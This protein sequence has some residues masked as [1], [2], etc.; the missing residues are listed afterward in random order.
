[1]IDKIKHFFFEARVDQN[2]LPIFRISIAF[3][4]L[5]HFL[6][7]QEDFFELYAR[8]GII[9]GDIADFF[10]HRYEPTLYKLNLFLENH[11]G[12]SE[13]LS[14]NFFRVLFCVSLFCLGIGFLTRFNALV[15]LILQ[16]MLVKTS[17]FFAYG[18]D[19]FTSISL[20]YCFIFPVGSLW[21]VDN[22]WMQRQGG[23]NFATAFKRLFQLHVSIAYFF[24]GF[25]K[26][27]GYNWWNGESIWKAINL[28]YFN[29]DFELQF[30]WMSSYPWLLIMLGWGTILI[31][32]M[33][34]LFIWIKKTRDTWLF[35]T[36]SLHLGIAVVFNLYFFSL[37]MIVWNL[38]CFFDFRT[39][40]SQIKLKNYLKRVSIITKI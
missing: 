1:M 25:D 23:E 26:I 30:Q 31:E 37:I 18:V 29:M 22:L 13:T 3:L 40:L 15:S 14:F 38:T 8:D 20:F 33:Y 19:Y 16:L 12:I 10:T 28:P 4:V 24:S 17:P 32:M 21:S 6:S 11:F 7:I 35:L 36:I 5:F 39:F 9:P 27:L 2:Y 34:P